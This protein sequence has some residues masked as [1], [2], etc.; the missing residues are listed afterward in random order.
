[1]DPNPCLFPPPALAARRPEAFLSPL[2]PLSSSHPFTSFSVS[3]RFHLLRRPSPSPHL[4]L[5]LHRLSRRRTLRVLVEEEEHEEGEKGGQKRKKTRRM[6]MT[7]RGGTS[8]RAARVGLP[9]RM[10]AL[11]R[12]ERKKKKKQIK[13]STAPPHPRGL[14]PPAVRAGCRGAPTQSSSRCSCP[15]ASSSP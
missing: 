2:S 13:S 11:Q 12:D 15:R 4:L 10:T 1:M 3:L 5:V 9:Y 14:G 7:R 8:G 6:S